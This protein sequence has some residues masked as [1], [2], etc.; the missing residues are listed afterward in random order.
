MKN[1]TDLDPQSGGLQ[2]DFVLQSLKTSHLI[3]SIG[4]SKVCSYLELLVQ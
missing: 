4:V 2:D 1:I 3:S